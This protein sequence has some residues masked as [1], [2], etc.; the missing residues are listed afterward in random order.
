MSLR[1]HNAPPD[2][3][4]LKP[5]QKP[6]DDCWYQPY[7]IGHNRLSVIVKRMCEKVGV[8]GYFTNHSLR[9]TCATR[10]YHH[11]ADEQQIMS[12]TGH[13]SKDAVRVY[14][15]MS[16]DQEEDLSEMISVNK[17][18]KEFVVK[19]KENAR[20]DKVVDKKKIVDKENIVENISKTPVFN[21]SNCTVT[22][23]NYS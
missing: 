3:F 16:R 7:P 5:L 23:N 19:E 17:K 9:R 10:L 2:I 15:T 13:R 8:E 18:V 20:D 6:F 1:P 21:F 4:Y 14:K 11:G 22:F 12:V